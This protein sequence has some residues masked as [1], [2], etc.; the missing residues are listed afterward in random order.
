RVYSLLRF[1]FLLL[2]PPPSS[3]LFP[4]TTLFRSAPLPDIGLIIVDEEHD[5]SY[6]Q[7]ESPRYNGRDVAI[8]RGQR[9]DA[10]VVLGSATPSMESYHNAMNG[11]YERVILERRV[12]DRPLAAV[13][14]VD[15]R[16]EYA[17]E[18]P[19]AVLSRA[20]KNAIAARLA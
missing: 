5:A 17:V 14:V 19:E 9:A 6:K 16:E 10:L 8:I 7:E 2:P 15:M 12:L 1:F 3:T 20:L 11:R 4:Y 13:S 18:G